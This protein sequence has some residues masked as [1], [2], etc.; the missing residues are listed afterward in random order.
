MCITTLK[1]IIQFRTQTDVVTDTAML[2]LGVGAVQEL[3]KHRL[4]P[5]IVR[6]TALAMLN[7]AYSPIR[8]APSTRSD[9]KRT[10]N[11]RRSSI[12]SNA[13]PGSLRQGTSMWCSPSTQS[14]AVKIGAME[15]AARAL[16]ARVEIRDRGR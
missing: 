7:S 4:V 16:D 12:P 11:L 1:Q 13:G 2:P 10:R 9:A 8:D 14:P 15:W 5:Y 3:A 6:D